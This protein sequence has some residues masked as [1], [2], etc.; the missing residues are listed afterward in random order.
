MID[1]I[2]VDPFGLKKIPS[3]AKCNQVSISNF[4]FV[5][6][7][8]SP[9]KNGIGIN[10]FKAKDYLATSNTMGDLFLDMAKASCQAAFTLKTVT[11]NFADYGIIRHKGTKE[12]LAPKATMAK[13][14]CV[15]ACIK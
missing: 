4:D 3:Q 12:C 11:P 13:Q 10:K 8:S 6:A 14:A 2:G 9:S 5:L 7:Q 15:S 1:S